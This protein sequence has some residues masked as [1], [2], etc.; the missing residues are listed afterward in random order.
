MKRIYIFPRYSGDENSDWYQKVQRE[1][2]HNDKNITIIPLT[3]PNW[4]KPSTDEFLSFIREVIPENK[5]DSNTYF[6]GHSIGCKAA[7][8]YL[9]ELHISNPKLIMGGLL[10]VAGWWSIDKPWPQ[11]KPWIKMP[12]DFKGIKLI[13]SNNIVSI[14]SDN[15][16][17]TSDTQSNKKLW[18]KNLSAKVVIV[19][20]AKHFN[21][22]EGLIEIINEILPFSFKLYFL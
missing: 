6:I 13:C 20:G 1:F 19:P 22:S 11:L 15:D 12:I 8:L 14:L 2:V 17:Y 9:N 3:L 7:L 16:P 21:D 4:D 18:E 5:I 10:C